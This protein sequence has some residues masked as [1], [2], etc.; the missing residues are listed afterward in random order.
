MCV[1]N[2]GLAR[3][4]FKTHLADGGGG[5]GPNIDFLKAFYGVQSRKAVPEKPEGSMYFVENITSVTVCGG[6]TIIEGRTIVFDEYKYC[7]YFF[8]GIGYSVSMS[9]PLDMVITQGYVYGINNVN[10]YCGFFLGASAN[11]LVTCYGG[12][13]ANPEVYAEIVS[14]MSYAPSLGASA[15]WYTTNQTGWIYGKANLSPDVNP[16]QYQF[17]NEPMSL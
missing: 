7:E 2:A 12:A 10:D 16:Y 17:S 14:G 13:W 8:V 6:M 11:M 3:C 9:I 4:H 1:D 5:Y 15:T